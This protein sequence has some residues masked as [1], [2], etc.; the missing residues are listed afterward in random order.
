MQ[1]YKV[2]FQI[3]D[4]QK[5]LIIMYISIFLSICFAVSSQS[6]ENNEEKTF[7]S[8][9]YKLAIFDA[10]KTE[11]SQGLTAYLSQENEIVEIADGKESIQDELYNRNVNCVLRI[12]Q[13]FMEEEKK[14]EYY[15]IPGTIGGETIQNLTNRYISI[16]KSYVAGGY[17]ITEA[18][19]TAK[20]VAEEKVKIELTEEENSTSFSKSYYFFSYIPYVM[21]SICIIAI[22]PI[23]IVFHRKEVRERV[24][25]SAYTNYRTNMELFAGTVTAGVGLCLLIFLM[26]LS[27]VGVEV[28]SFKG[29]LNTLNMITFL[30]V[31]LGATFLLG[32]MVK[33]RN[34][35]SMVSN[36]VALGMSF[37]S[38]IFVPLELLGDSVIAVARFLPSYWYI[39]AARHIDHYE[40][41]VSHGELWGAMGIELLF[42]IALIAIGLAYSKTKMKSLS[43]A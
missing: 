24:Q 25:C 43:V 41:A 28:L 2:F 37:L 17:S 29:F 33:N 15:S 22:A 38:G 12:P 20:K 13:G 21:F 18:V 34:V 35:L 26:I 4:K 11:L 1:V 16:T 32:Q 9:S 19:Q 8:Q 40:T 6:V 3:L 7:S 31:S 5:G 27:A 42:G 30:I 10:D 36:V 14:I 23:L 39:V